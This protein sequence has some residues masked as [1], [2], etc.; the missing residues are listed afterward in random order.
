MFSKVATGILIFNGI[1]TDCLPACLPA[2][3]PRFFTLQHSF[4][5]NGAFQHTTAHAMH[6]L[7]NYQCPP[8][9]FI[10]HCL[11]R[12]Y[13]VGDTSDG[14]LC[15]MESLIIHVFH[16]SYITEVLFKVLDSY[17]YALL[18]YNVNLVDSK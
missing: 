14:F 9:C 10:R 17:C 12:K 11:Q 8:L 6:S 3:L 7:W 4:N 1:S 5:L 15:M 2:C 13:Q 16:R 18:M